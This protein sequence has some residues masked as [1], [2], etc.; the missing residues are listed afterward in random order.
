[1]RSNLTCRDDLFFQNEEIF[2]QLD[3]LYEL[4]MHEKHSVTASKKHRKHS[5]V[6]VKVPDC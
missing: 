5:G 6:M 2:V 3:E 4:P 1:M